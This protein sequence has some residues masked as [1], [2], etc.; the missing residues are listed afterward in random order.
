MRNVLPKHA[1]LIPAHAERVFSGVIY[2]VFQWE[3]ELYDGSTAVFEML[4]RPDTVKVLAVKDD[5]IV[6]LEQEQPGH[7]RFFDTPGGRHDVENESELDAAK[8]ELLEESGMTFG[9]WR[10]LDVHQRHTKIETFQYIFLAT[11]FLKQVPPRPDA[12]EK[13][14]V[15]LM[16]LEGAKKL[17]GHHK[18]RYLPEQILSNVYSIQELI[19]YPEY[20]S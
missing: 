10:L 18:A 20:D 14:E 13:I 16:T 2:D 17:I 6:I 19:D 1:A 12:G 11:A 7:K 3:Q 8:R 5:K 15:H 4:R 9:A